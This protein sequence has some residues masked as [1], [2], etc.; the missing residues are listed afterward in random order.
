MLVDSGSTHSF[1]SSKIATQWSDVRQ[2]RPMNVTLADG[3]TLQC[4]LEVP[5]CV[6]QAQGE[7]FT[8]TLRLFSLGCYDIIL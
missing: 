1:I 3:G 7:E 6:W 2:C 8:T 4:D 5:G